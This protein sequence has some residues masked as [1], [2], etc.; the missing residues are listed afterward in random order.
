[1]SAIHL[2][3]KGTRNRGLRLQG[4]SLARFREI[5]K[6]LSR[7]AQKPAFHFHRHRAQPQNFAG[8]SPILPGPFPKAAASVEPAGW[9]PR[10]AQVLRDPA[11]G[12]RPRGVRQTQ[13]AA[14]TSASVRV[15]PISASKWSL[16]PNQIRS[17]RR[18]GRLAVRRML[19]TTVAIARFEAQEGNPSRASER[20]SV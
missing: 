2:K 6:D 14:S 18:K 5:V 19:S 1:M 15:S 11:V 16:R 9:K 4:P 7:I 3:T 17:G 8:A 13:R 10:L 20:A 12:H